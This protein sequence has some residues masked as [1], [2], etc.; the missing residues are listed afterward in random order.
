M[1]GTWQ[2]AEIIWLSKTEQVW[3]QTAV[4]FKVHY[5]LLALK[6]E[7]VSFLLGTKHLQTYK[8]K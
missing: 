1:N 6:V 5:L 2:K 4:V 7:I 8:R 3:I